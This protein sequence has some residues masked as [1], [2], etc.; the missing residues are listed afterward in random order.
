MDDLYNYINPTTN[1]HSP[2]ISAETRSV[3]L[4]NVDRLNS[5]MIY[6]RDYL[7]NY[8]GFKVSIVEQG[9]VWENCN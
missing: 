8:F 2:L 3:I 4:A 6:D 1:K 5:A 7:F 9:I